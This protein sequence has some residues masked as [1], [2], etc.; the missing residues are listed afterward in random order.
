MTRIYGTE[1][2]E[3]RIELKAYCDRCGA[4]LAP[5]TFPGPRTSEGTCGMYSGALRIRADGWYGGYID[6]MGSGPAIDLCKE[7]ADAFVRFMGVDDIYEL[8]KASRWDG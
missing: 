3:T 4:F 2:R 8:D 5:V 7:C 6:P 1:M